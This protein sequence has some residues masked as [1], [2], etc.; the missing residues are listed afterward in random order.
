MSDDKLFEQWQEANAHIR[1]WERLLFENARAAIGAIT[2]SIGVAGL[3][4]SFRGVDSIGQRLIVAAL[5]LLAAL[6]AALSYRQTQSGQRNLSR[7]FSLR[8]QLGEQGKFALGDDEHDTWRE[9]RSHRLVARGFFGV[10][11]LCV[12]SAYAVLLLPQWFPVRTDAQAPMRVAVDGFS[13]LTESADRMARAMNRL[14]DG[15]HSVG[16]ASSSPFVNHVGD[17]PPP[18]R[19]PF[20]AVAKESN[21]TTSLVVAGLSMALA[22]AGVFAAFRIAS[23]TIRAIVV[24]SSLALGI[25]GTLPLS[26]KG[27]VNL[28]GDFSCG[29][30][31]CI[32][33]QQAGSVITALRSTPS[34]DIGAW[35]AESVV[36][37]VGPQYANG[38]AAWDKW[39][40]S[41][42][43]R[44]LER[45]DP[46]AT[47]VVLLWGSADPQRLS[48][49]LRQRHETNGG[50]ALA[51]AEYVASLLQ[52]VTGGM[53]RPQDR[54]DA[55][56]IM[57]LAAGPAGTGGAP[58][59]ATGRSPCDD[60]ARA[61][62]RRVSVWIQASP[63]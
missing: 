30:G 46:K 50:L 48:G 12:I 32:R 61:Q 47:D 3:V 19:L 39:R 16:P 28:K 6:L 59:V 60:E 13:G 4:A 54:L 62:Q 27:E 53:P 33:V 57:T 25:A 55:T 22:L 1:H 51:R 26:F 2:A 24:T 37:C 11:V 31:G 45:K 18:E 38:D 21:S 49:P 43:Q 34:F 52:E 40:A 10:G 35:N 8:A 29:S 44:W 63:N 36:G 15:L 5:L 41:F 23:P 14:A 7:H 9:R 58:K 56:R 17:S 42:K 20:D